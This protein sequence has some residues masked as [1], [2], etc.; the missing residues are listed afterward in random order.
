MDFNAL[1]MM[2][3]SPTAMQITKILGQGKL[4]PADA[5]KLLASAGD[6]CYLA[7]LPDSFGESNDMTTLMFL[8]TKEARR[9][10]NQAFSYIDFTSDD[11]LPSWQTPDTVGGVGANITAEFDSATSPNTVGF[12]ASTTALTRRSTRPVS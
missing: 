5:T 10:G 4:E 7:A 11:V 6:M 12:M 9:D 1:S 2:G 3:A 8:Q